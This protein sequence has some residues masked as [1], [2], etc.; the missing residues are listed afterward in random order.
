MQPAASN[1]VGRELADF[2]S[3]RVKAE[4]EA[5]VLASRQPGGFWEITLQQIYD[6]LQAQLHLTPE[7]KQKLLE[8]ELSTEAEFSYA[9]G[10]VLVLYN[11]ALEMGKRVFFVS[12]MY[13]PAAQLERLLQT[14]GY[15]E[16]EVYVS[17]EIGHSK[18][19]GDLYQHLAHRL[20]IKT[21]QVVHVG[22]NW[23][24]DIIQARRKGWRAVH[25]Q[26][27]APVHQRAHELAAHL[28]NSV[29]IGLIREYENLEA[30]KEPNQR[31]VWNW[32]G[33]TVTGPVYFA[34]ACW[35]IA[36]AKSMGIERIYPC[37]RDG[38]SIV[39][40]LEILQETWKFKFDVRYLYA[41]RKIYR[42]PTIR[43]LGEKELDFLLM[44]TPGLNVRDFV[45][46]CNRVPEV[47]EP[48][49]RKLGF[50]SLDMPVT[51]SAFG[52]FIRPEFGQ[53]LR[54]WL[55]QIE[56]SLLADYARDR[57]LA[58]RYLKQEGVHL[59]NGLIVDVGWA[60][61]I[62]RS[63]QEILDSMHS[64]IAMKSCFFGT[65]E[66]VDSMVRP[67]GSL[68]SY[69]FHLGKPKRRLQLHRECVEL[70][71]LL[72]SAP[73]PTAV[74]LHVNNSS[75][76]EP[77]FGQ[78]EHTEEESRN[79]ASM[80]DAAY[81]FVADAARLLGHSPDLMETERMSDLVEERLIRLLR[82]PTSAEAA[83]IGRFGHWHG[84][85]D[86]GTL[87]RLAR[88]PVPNRD[89]ATLHELVDAYAQAFW[90]KGLLVQVAPWQAR[91]LPF[92]LLLKSV[93][94]ALST[95]TVWK[96]MLWALFRIE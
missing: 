82:R 95:G 84:F 40:S 1:L 8:L 69:F 41:S 74:G 75:I 27:A 30:Q 79:L 42:L 54:Q 93:R 83:T 11:T 88:L 22:D 48:L 17:G 14:R 91:V 38:Y 18:H 51:E 43:K 66:R 3:Q 50:A 67:G 68:H 32:V 65:I 10:D 56:S 23:R 64:G 52:R 20:S 61:T 58:S 31:D 78:F 72:F 47:E 46:R 87:R 4:R 45:E 13:L 9:N 33:Y 5:R 24:S 44:A 81:R 28:S 21:G 80:R 70:V 62:V 39:R 35:L 63:V 15:Q 37:S 57:E 73:H 7:Q 16:P 36:Q 25:Y 6:Q 71:E 26:P 12:D 96:S 29:M 34:F 53:W 76:I 19:Q 59:P 94:V 92:L 90:K 2:K 55:R 77:T 85:G 49:L 89:R 60:G 86:K